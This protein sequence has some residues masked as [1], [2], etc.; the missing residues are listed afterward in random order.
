MT[1]PRAPVDVAAGVLIRRDGKFLL[2]SR[3]A[4]KP[5][6]SYWEFP[7]GK[8]EPGES[9]A[10]ALTRELH[11]E[12]GIDIGM[13][14]PW[15][16]RIFDYPHALVRLHFFRVFDW[17]GELRAREHQ[18]FG[19]FSTTDLPNGPLLPATLPVLRWLALA[20]IY[21]ISAAAQLGGEVFLRRLDLAL[22]RGLR[23]LQFREPGLDDLDAKALFDQVRIRARAAG[24][25]LLVSSRHPPSLWREAD[26]VHLTSADLASLRQRPELE[27]VG[28]SVHSTAEIEHASQLQLDFVT[29]GPVCTTPTHPHHSPIGWKA[30]AQMIAASSVPVYSL[31][32]KQVSDLAT[33][34]SHGAHGL[35]SL[36]AVWSDPQCDRLDSFGVWSTSLSSGPATV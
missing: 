2:A 24:A 4:G 23:L 15:V 9:V 18:N 36:S 33:A 12:L 22:A 35:A 28:A 21:A 13:A 5:Y 8:I 26:G 19:F 10:T 34:L 30:F 6:A 29:A 7:G 14:Y 25:T 32:G 20:P 27:W 17:R 11:E 1:P 16:V 31:G 3:P